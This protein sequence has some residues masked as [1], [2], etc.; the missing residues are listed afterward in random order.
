MTTALQLVLSNPT[1]GMEEAFNEWYAGPHLIHGV[2][3]PG[4]VSGQRF[5]RASGP[6]PAGKHDYL[7]IWEIDD[8]A[9]ALAELAKVKG[10]DTMPI[11]PA[12][13]MQTVQPPT[14]WRR[15]EIRSTAL[16]ANDTSSFG[17]IVFGL[18]NA[19]EGE[20]P[21]F[22]EAL[23]TGGLAGIADSAGVIAAQY[24]TLAEAQIRGN[25]RKFPH[26]ILIELHHEADAL[27]ALTEKLATLPH[28]DPARWMAIVFRP[29]GPR[30]TKRDARD[31]AQHT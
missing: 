18:Y 1:V 3:T 25:A 13:D 30:L 15:A 24:L 29:M 4:I 19:A 5:K 27:A 14:M 11:S 6:W 20:D 22:A 16:I 31:M 9:Y 2:Q 7:M 26:G 8:P 21:A 28:A 23:L 17:T 10:S 12:I